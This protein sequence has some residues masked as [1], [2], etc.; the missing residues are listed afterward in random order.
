M[1]RKRVKISTWV[2]Y[3]HSSQWEFQPNVQ[4]IFL[5]FTDYITLS[6]MLTKTCLCGL[7][8][9]A[10]L[11]ETATFIN[12][13]MMELSVRTKNTILKFFGN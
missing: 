1:L 8:K 3:Y 2:L 9:E 6:Q 13:L 7:T 4:N 11:R 5:P 10:G 12:A